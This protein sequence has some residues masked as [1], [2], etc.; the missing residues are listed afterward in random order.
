MH[1][2]NVTRCDLIIDITKDLRLF[3]AR[4]VFVKARTPI[5]NHLLMIGECKRNVN[6]NNQSEASFRTPRGKR[7]RGSRV[8]ITEHLKGRGGAWTHHW[9][10]ICHL[11]RGEPIRDE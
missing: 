6:S 9:E 1:L 3:P 4:A 5:V 7:K 11:R 8:T 10:T 2:N